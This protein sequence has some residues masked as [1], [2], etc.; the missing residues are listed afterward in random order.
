MKYFIFKQSALARYT[1]INVLTQHA[2]L[3]RKFPRFVINADVR[4]RD[5]N[6][7]SPIVIDKRREIVEAHF[8]CYS[9]TVSV[10]F[11]CCIY[12]LS[13]TDFKPFYL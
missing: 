11:L 10:R 6:D 8:L 3:N 12:E 5:F 2:G 9:G 1:C 13:I 4:P 7:S